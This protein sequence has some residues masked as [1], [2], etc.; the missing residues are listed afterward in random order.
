MI[1]LGFGGGFANWTKGCRH[2]L[3][4]DEGERG[5]VAWLYGFE[6]AAR[7]YHVAV[8]ELLPQ[9]AKGTWSGP[10]HC[11]GTFALYAHH[12]RLQMEGGSG[13][14]LQRP[15]A[16]RRRGPPLRERGREASRGYRGPA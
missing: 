15:P 8:F 11:L 3:A 1:A 12:K 7:L 6:T 5:E 2:P 16:R 9:N 13:Q 10:L 4:L 14:G